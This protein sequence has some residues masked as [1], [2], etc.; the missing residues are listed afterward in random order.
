MA[1]CGGSGSFIQPLYSAN[2]IPGCLQLHAEQGFLCYSYE[3]YQDVANT[4]HNTV[5][6][7][8]CMHFVFNLIEGFSAQSVRVFDIARPYEIGWFHEVSVFLLYLN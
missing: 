5:Y 8:Y 2:T 4:G 3:A 7:I 6:L 1:A